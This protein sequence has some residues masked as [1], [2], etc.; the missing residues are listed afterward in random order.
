M[1]LEGGG[2]TGLS[3]LD[4]LS[5]CPLQLLLQRFPWGFGY[6]GKGHVSLCPRLGFL[7]KP[8]TM[9][10]AAPV[11]RPPGER[12]NLGP[13]SISSSMGK[14]HVSLCPRLG[15][16][17]KPCTMYMAAPVAR[18]LGERCNLSPFFLW[19]REWGEGVIRPL[20]LPP[21]CLLLLG[22]V[23]VLCCCQLAT[24]WPF[25]E[26]FGLASAN[27]PPSGHLANFFMDFGVVASRVTGWGK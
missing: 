9:Y 16:L 3:T 6:L 10:M 12:P 25:G 27:W 24:F 19:G 5:W 2:P 7:V 17:V 8:C 18:P 15:F 14:G 13:F 21:C 23:G 4:F 22:S 26:V 1:F 20:S 11:A